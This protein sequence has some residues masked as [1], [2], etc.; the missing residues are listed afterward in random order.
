MVN[1]FSNSLNGNI[2]NRRLSSLHPVWEETWRQIRSGA[3]R[4]RIGRSKK[5]K[6]SYYRGILNTKGWIKFETH[7]QYIVGKMYTQYIK[8]LDIKD[9]EDM[10]EFTEKDII[11]VMLQGDIKVYCSC[12][13]FHYKGFKYMGHQMGWGIYREDRFPKI[14]NPKLEGTVCKHL[15]KVFEVYMLNWSKISKDMKKSKYFRKRWG[16]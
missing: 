3:D 2:F 9:L 4:P 16:S 5:I 1:S 12:K 6:A 13:D 7:S 14:R 10:K 11:R 8:M 15:L